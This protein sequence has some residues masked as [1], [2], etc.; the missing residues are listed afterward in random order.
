MAAKIPKEIKLPENSFTD[1]ASCEK[2]AQYIS[3]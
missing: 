3:T 2:N 1:I